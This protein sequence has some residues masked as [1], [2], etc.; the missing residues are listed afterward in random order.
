VRCRDLE[1]IHEG[2]EAGPATGAEANAA[3]AEAI[4]QAAG[5]RYAQ[6]FRH[7]LAS[8]LYVLSLP[9]YFDHLW[10]DYIQ[11][12]RAEYGEDG[13]T[14]VSKSEIRRLTFALHRAQPMLLGDVAHCIPPPPPRAAGQ[15][16]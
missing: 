10:S 11:A 16:G 5:G 14:P 4:R 8:H 1:T 6:E 3:P 15:A 2:E 12:W 9:A 7:R 13:V